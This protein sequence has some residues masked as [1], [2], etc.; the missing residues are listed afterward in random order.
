MNRSKYVQKIG[1]RALA[2]SLGELLT[3]NSRESGGFAD[4][5]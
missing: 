3:V 1:E 4:L 5:P 2:F